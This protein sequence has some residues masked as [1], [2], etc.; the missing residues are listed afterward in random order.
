MN[1]RAIRK[2]HNLT[3]EDLAN[4]LG[5][6][7]SAYSKLERGKIQLTVDRLLALS[8]YF[9]LSPEEI[10][11]F[12]DE[13]KNSG[14]PQR[15]RNVTY[16]P[17]AAQAGWLND[18]FPQ[19]SGESGVEFSLPVFYEDDLFLINLE[20]DSMYPT[21]C[22]GDYVLAQPLGS[23][24]QIKWGEAYLIVTNKGQVIKRVMK[25]DSTEKLLLRSDNELYQPYEIERSSI[26]S[27]WEVKGVI[28][29]NLAPRLL[30]QA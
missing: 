23:D 10:L 22:N 9:N 15:R 4:M 8:K 17:V 3:Q 11:F 19:Q 14:Y 12:G 28:S 24:F 7:V 20:G 2:A 21:L 18:F 13:S 1:I 25:S 16:I 5:I 6:K 30:R 29:K 26:R 27:I